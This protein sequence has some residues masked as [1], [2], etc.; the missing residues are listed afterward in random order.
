MLLLLLLVLIKAN[1][2]K[3]AVVVDTAA[4]T[5]AL[6]P[7][8][9]TADS[10]RPRFSRYKGKQ[11]PIYLYETNRGRLESAAMKIGP[12][13]EAKAKPKYHVKIYNKFENCKQLYVLDPGA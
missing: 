7:Y 13:R 1:A 11:R 2:R 5:K 6:R 4:K 8:F 9:L 12:L 10:N 3:F